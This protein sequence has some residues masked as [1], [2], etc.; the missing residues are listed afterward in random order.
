MLYKVDAIYVRQLVTEKIDSLQ[1][2]V[3]QLWTQFRSDLEDWEERKDE[4][5][6]QFQLELEHWA[7]RSRFRRRFTPRPRLRGSTYEVYGPFRRVAKTVRL[8]RDPSSFPGNRREVIELRMLNKIR[9]YLSQ[10]EEGCLNLT[11]TELRY[12]NIDFSKVLG[13]VSEEA[14]RPI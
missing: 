7:S 6:L 12:F 3:E 5:L 11:L 2:N 14:N 1:D 4:F 13:V 8:E 9:C 10:V